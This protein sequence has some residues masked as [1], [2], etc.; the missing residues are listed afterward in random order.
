MGARPWPAPT[1]TSWGDPKI[2]SPNSARKYS[3]EPLRWIY[4]D[5]LVGSAQGLHAAY[6]LN[7]KHLDTGFKG[8]LLTSFVGLGSGS[9][10]LGSGSLL[11]GSIPAD[12]GSGSLPQDHGPA[13]SRAL[14]SMTPS[15]EVVIFC[16]S[17]ESKL[18]QTGGVCVC[19]YIHIH[20]Y[21]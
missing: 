8:P 14:V 1:Q 19:I 4:L 17:P 21:M 6:S 7:L 13:G 2:K 10:R 9:G 11:L 18:C 3:L 20:T 5:L 15:G 16:N 12:L